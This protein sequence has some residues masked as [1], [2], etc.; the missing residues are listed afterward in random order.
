MAHIHTGYDLTNC[1]QLGDYSLNLQKSS[2]SSLLSQQG[3]LR[4]MIQE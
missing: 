3:D 2:L 4:H 1:V